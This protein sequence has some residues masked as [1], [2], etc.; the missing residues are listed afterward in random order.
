MADD[1][2]LIGRT[3]TRVS[4]ARI[5]ALPS[6][7]SSGMSHRASAG[8][9]KV[10]GQTLRRPRAPGLTGCRPST[11]E[12]PGDR[13]VQVVADEV[14]VGDRSVLRDQGAGRDVGHPVG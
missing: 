1:L 13:V 7:Q 10:M 3:G 14:D 6:H 2:W 12:F 4:L 5:P 8:I 9:V 11:R